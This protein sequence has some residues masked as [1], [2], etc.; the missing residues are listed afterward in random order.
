MTN[1]L[2]RLRTILEA[3]EVGDLPGLDQL[4]ALKHGG[5]AYEATMARL[6]LWPELLAVVEAA[7][8]DVSKRVVSGVVVES[9]AVQVTRTSSALDALYVAIREHL[10]EEK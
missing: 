7:Q 9:C 3:G 10:K 8:K 6:H 4:A 2:A 1:E 5:V